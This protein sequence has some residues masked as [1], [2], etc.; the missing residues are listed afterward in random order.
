M[1][2]T[3]VNKTFLS[4]LLLAIVYM[5]G[6]I[7]VVSGRGTEIMTLTWANLL[8][9]AGVFLFNAEKI[10]LKYILWFL[11]V[12]LAGFGVEVIGV[13]TGFVFGEYSYGEILGTKLLDTPLI[14][15]VN[16][17]VLVFATASLVQGFRV[18]PFTKAFIAAAIMV[19]YDVVLEPVAIKTGMWA[20]SSQ[21][22]PVQNYFAWFF[23]SFGLLY[24]A[25]AFVKTLK[26]KTAFP[27][28]VMQVIFFVVILSYYGLGN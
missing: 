8:F 11:V 10:N 21:Q 9:A 18:S 27:L 7:A 23:I 4:T 5:V 15:G 6:I 26:N 14:I 24:G 16:W 2:K 1:R 13:K 22:V 20:W 25:F 17:S 12:F 28:L 3:I 19:I